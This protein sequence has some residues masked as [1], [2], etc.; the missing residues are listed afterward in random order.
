MADSPTKGSFHAD[1]PADAVEEALRSVER[2][3]G[4]AA[5][6][7]GAEVAV[8]AGAAAPADDG[9]SERERSLAAQL[10]LSQEKSRETMERLKETHDRYLR[11][12]AELENYRKRAQK[13]RDE[14][15]KYGNEKLLKDLFPV[16]DN[17]D[18]ALAAV[19]GGAEGDARDADPLVK[20]VKMVRA[21]LES[22]LAKHGVTSFSAMGQPFDPAKHEALLQV[23]TADAAPGTVVLE[24]A[25]GFLLHDRLARPA[26]VGVAK[27]PEA[28]A[29]GGDGGADGGTR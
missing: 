6:E 5:P 2:I 27:P 4:G 17:L 23:A 13:E 25:R 26:M 8:E 20:G 18:R 16:V 21:S 10:E 28:G 14:V 15:L 11:A 1:I 22:A 12:A 9:G 24:H 7:E 29:A 19:T 3:H